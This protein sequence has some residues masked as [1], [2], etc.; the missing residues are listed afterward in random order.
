[1]GENDGRAKAVDITH[2][3][4]LS[5][6]VGKD[7]LQAKAQ[8][9]QEFIAETDA[10]FTATAQGLSRTSK[11]RG[12]RQVYSYKT[13]GCV[14]SIY[15]DDGLVADTKLFEK[16]NSLRPTSKPLDD[17]RLEGMAVRF[18]NLLH[19]NK[20]GQTYNQDMVRAGDSSIE[21]ANALF[22]VTEN[23]TPED[24]FAV[25]KRA[26]QI[27]DELREKH[28]LPNLF[29]A[30][31][32]LNNDGIAHEL[33]RMKITSPGG[34]WDYPYV[35]IYD[36]G[37]VDRSTQP[38]AEAKAFYGPEGFR[39]IDNKLFV[40]P[41]KLVELA[42]NLSTTDGKI[43][44]ETVKFFKKVLLRP[45]YRD[46]DGADQLAEMLE[47][48]LKITNRDAELKIKWETEEV[49]KGNQPVS[50]LVAHLQF[51]WGPNKG[52]DVVLTT[53]PSLTSHLR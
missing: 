48:Q 38:N 19:E 52:S 6:I 17:D 5:S 20:F 28:S 22:T 36:W 47:K 51:F 7:V 4:I 13:D 14:E 40:N 16:R 43:D 45:G 27:N 24:R 42:T 46:F 44:S 21:A 23:L 11:T 3:D 31:N 30:F 33:T 8:L 18:N 49:K 35:E 29:V 53:A 9:L 41:A 12:N 32:D 1:M 26:E 50:Q 34:R 10:G 25:L 2:E 39:V 37:S 15:L